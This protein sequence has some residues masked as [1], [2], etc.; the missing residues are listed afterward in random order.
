MKSRPQLVCACALALMALVLLPACNRK[1][2]KDVLRIGI[3]RSLQTNV[4]RRTQGI[5]TPN[6][7]APEQFMGDTDHRSDIYAIG[8]VAYE[9]LSYR[10]AV[11]GDST[12]SV[13][14]KIVLEQPPPLTDVC[15]DLDPAIVAIV[16]KAL[17]KEPANRYQDVESMRA[18]VKRVAAR[19]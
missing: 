11:D 6:Y 18:D 9:L 7:M 12:F 10:Q 4:Q 15:P 13:M 16:N 2:A 19:F 3:A 5:G 1:P 17:E 14:G 8:A